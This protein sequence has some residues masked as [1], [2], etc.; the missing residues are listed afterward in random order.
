MRKIFQFL[1][2]AGLSV[3]SAKA[4]RLPPK[5]YRELVHDWV[6]NHA[7]LA[8]IAIDPRRNDQAGD[9][10]DE[11]RYT[12]L[13]EMEKAQ[14]LAAQVETRPWSG[15]YWP[16]YAGELANRYGDPGY[17][18]GL[19]WKDNAKYLQSMLGRGTSQDLSPAEKYD[20]LVG[21]ASFTL[22]KHMIQAGAPYADRDGSVPTWFG[23]CH[24]WAPA[25][26]MESRPEHSVKVKAPDGREI[27]FN[28]TD[29]KALASLLWANGAGRTRFISG[30]CNTPSPRYD[31]NHRESDPDCYDTNAA[32]WHL[33]VVNQ[34]GVSRRSFVVDISAAAEVWNQPAVGYH[35][36]YVN[37]VTGLKSSTLAGAKVRLADW[38]SD[39]YV[40]T[41]SSRAVSV[42]KI[43]MA[44]EYGSETRASTDGEDR[45]ELDAHASQNYLYDL[46]LDENDNIVGGEWYSGAHPDFLWVPVKGSQASSSGDADLDR[47]GDQAAWN[48]TEVVPK[49]WRSAAR[50][51][52]ADEQPLARIVRRLLDISRSR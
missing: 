10:V 38:R 19:S 44:F 20:L 43:S 35:Y 14:L 1:L 50:I 31:E 40:H 4:E 28:P 32:T 48:G 47:R 29:L 25:A 17:K 24:G 30:R 18:E 37:P 15:S 8:F 23:I 12:S 3:S 45:E 2:F 49:S 46:E 42:V 22:T 34:I 6:R 52:S 36:S 5:A 9:F 21:D 41:R 13:A 39:P 11:L 27:E 26:F 16:I 33:A 51:A 7:E